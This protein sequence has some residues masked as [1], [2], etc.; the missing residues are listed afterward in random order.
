MIQGLSFHEVL[1]RILDYRAIADP[2][3]REKLR[4][5][6]TLEQ[7]D[8]QTRDLPFA[9]PDEVKILYQWHDGTEEDWERHP[10]I[11]YHDFRPLEEVIE[12]YLQLVEDFIDIDPEIAELLPLFEY[13]NEYYLSQCNAQQRNTGLIYSLYHDLTIE[14]DSLTSMF[15]AFLECYEIVALTPEGSPGHEK[16][17][18]K[19][20]VG[21]IKLKWNPIRERVYDHP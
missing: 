13:E 18:N 6:L 14:Y 10:L 3:L 17:I 15:C 7:I 12:R 4:P 16:V 21:E 20:Q 1:E 8:K 11:G 19:Q 9:L 5:G 2:Y